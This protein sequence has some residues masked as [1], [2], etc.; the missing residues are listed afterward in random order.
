MNRIFKELVE[1]NGIDDSTYEKLTNFNQFH[2]DHIY[3]I[4]NESPDVEQIIKVWVDYNIEDYKIVKTHVGC[5]CEGQI[6]TGYKAFIYGDLKLKLEYVSDKYC[7]SVHSMNV[8]IPFS[9]YV[10]LDGS[11]N[12]YST[13]CSSIHIEDIYCDQLSCRNIYFN[14]TLMSIVDVC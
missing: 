4:P 2:I 13:I 9:S 5:S 12:E 10:T 11:Y 14:I 7:N 8:K 6:L 1:Y 3:N